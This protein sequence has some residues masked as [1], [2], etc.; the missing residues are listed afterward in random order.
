MPTVLFVQD[1]NAGHL[2]DRSEG[3]GDLE[4]GVAQWRARGLPLEQGSKADRWGASYDLQFRILFV[5][6]VAAASLGSSP[7][8]AL[9][10]W[11]QDTA[12]GARCTCFRTC[13][14]QC[15]LAARVAQSDLWQ[16]CRF[17]ASD[18]DAS[19]ARLPSSHAVCRLCQSVAA[20]CVLSMRASVWCCPMRS[21]NR[22][23]RVLYGMRPGD[24]Q[25]RTFADPV[26]PLATRA[27]RCARGAS[28]ACPSRTSASTS[29]SAC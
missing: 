23:S 24:A 3:T 20:G 26:L 6:C 8:L 4:M 21:A 14:H 17:W 7:G 13:S 16:L 10:T 5:R 27:G 15:C 29:S 11:A 19:F 28:R 2:T 1:G 12:V 22:G 25:L 9:R 18:R